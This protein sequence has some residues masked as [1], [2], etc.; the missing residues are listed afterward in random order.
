MT[1][2]PIIVQARLSSK[3]LPKKVLKEIKKLA[4]IDWIH[5]RLSNVNF[6][7]EIVIATSSAKSD[8]ELFQ[9]CL[10]KDYK[11]IR[12]SLNNVAKR[13]HQVLQPIDCKYIFRVCADSPFIDP[14]LLNAAYE[15]SFEDADIITNV[16]KRTYPKGQSVEL[17]N[18]KSFMNIYPY[19]NKASERE[20]I[21][22]RFYKDYKNYKIINF[23][24]THDFSQIRV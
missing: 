5:T 11:V 16:H 3:R 14:K 9:Y 24:S 8:D 15:L 12:G 2:I 23:E 10:K 22:S 17:I 13:F 21:T 19:L 4:V 20:H 1:S 6:K 18:K 7:N